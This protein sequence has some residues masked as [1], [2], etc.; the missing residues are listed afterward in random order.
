MHNKFYR[1][2][3][4]VIKFL[5]LDRLLLRKRIIHR[6][7]QIAKPKSLEFKNDVHHFTNFSAPPEKPTYLNIPRHFRCPDS[8][9]TFFSIVV[10]VYKPD[11]LHFLQ[12]LQSIKVQECLHYELILAF[13]GPMADMVINDL[14][15]RIVSTDSHIKVIKSENHSGISNTTNLAIR[16]S[17]GDWIVFVDQDDL[18]SSHIMPYLHDLISQDSEPRYIYTDHDK[19]RD[20]EHLDLDL[21]PDFSPTLLMSYMFIGHL[22]VIHKGIFETVGY[23]S[24]FYDGL[25]DYEFSLRCLAKDIRFEHIPVVGYSWRVSSKS[26]TNSNLKKKFMLS[27]KYIHALQNFATLMNFEINCFQYPWA[28]EQSLGIVNYS[29][30]NKGMLERITIVIPTIKFELI[31]A[32]IKSLAESDL[33]NVSLLIIDNT[34]DGN[35]QQSVLNILREEKFK[36]Y[37]VM[38]IKN[39]SGVFSYSRL[40]N[41]AVE[42]VATEEILFLNDDVRMISTDWLPEMQFHLNTF[43]CGIVGAKLL[44]GDMTV[45]HNGVLSRGHDDLP[46]PIFR[47]IKDNDGSYSNL[48]LLCREVDAVTAACML[49]RKGDFLKVGGFDEEEFAV[50]FNDI[51]FCNRALELGFTSIVCVDALGFHEEGSSRPRNDNPQEEYNYRKKYMNTTSRYYP[52]LCIPDQHNNYSINLKRIPIPNVKNTR[53][54]HVLVVSHNLN[55]EGAPKYLLPIVRLLIKSNISV[56]IASPIDGPMRYKF[57]QLGAKVMLSPPNPGYHEKWHRD[58]IDTIAN[59][60]KVLS[61]N[62][63]VANTSLSSEWVLGSKSAEIPTIW[64]IHEGAPFEDQFPIAPPWYLDRTYKA[65]EFSSLNIFVSK[66]SAEIFKPK[67]ISGNYRVINGSI[68]STIYFP[69]SYPKGT[70]LKFLSVGTFCERKNQYSLLKSF[71]EA[72]LDI[73]D[74]ATLTLIGDV[75]DEYSDKVKA[76]TEELRKN[77]LDIVIM[78]KISDE[79]ELA[80]IYRSSNVFVSSSLNESYPLT[81]LEAIGCG[82]PIIAFAVNGIVDQIRDGFNGFL[83]EPNNISSLSKRL[84]QLYD[85]TTLFSTLTSNASLQSK[86]SQY[87]ESLIKKFQEVLI[88]FY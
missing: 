88:D 3:V 51:D 37:R 8:D 18:L 65:L 79:N 36:N 58:Y 2:L 19:I 47:G 53:L 1:I 86:Y 49:V 76:K 27:N 32:C 74:S 14:L 29:H 68:D 57:E 26:L 55:L 72:F 35:L 38:H 21:K 77:G 34:D 13:D 4:T 5:G 7:I 25:Q 12:M 40:M 62:L 10:P 84:R 24:S 45:Q 31:Q 41:I 80:E 69:K 11:V 42:K 59:F 67:C 52:K 6:I 54:K 46:T 44:F 16:E 71:E 64:I 60:L 28:V 81:I 33:Q 22:K 70:K 39:I 9:K 85:D 78:E 20:N 17:K 61:V 50:A 73:P 23:F 30:T 48:N 56:T 63:V 43:D 83:V 82:L 15:A 66:S 75:N 87:E